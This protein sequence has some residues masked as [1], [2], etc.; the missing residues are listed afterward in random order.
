MVAVVL[1]VAGRL[2]AAAFVGGADGGAGTL[3]GPVG[4]DEDLTGQAGV[5]VPVSAAAVRS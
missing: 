4:E 1:L 3:V 2:V 5:D